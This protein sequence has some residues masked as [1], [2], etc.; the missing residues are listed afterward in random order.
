[1][2]LCRLAR[3]SYVRELMSSV[4]WDEVP[5]CQI[6]VIITTVPAATVAL[7]FARVRFDPELYEKSVGKPTQAFLSVAKATARVTKPYYRIQ[8]R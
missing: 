5:E 4:T 8:V 2:P 7:G 6:S 3:L 1:M